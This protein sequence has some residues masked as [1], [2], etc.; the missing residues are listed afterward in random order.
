MV[1]AQEICRLKGLP[2][3]DDWCLLWGLVAEGEG[4]A[5]LALKSK[6]ITADQVAD[7]IKERDGEKPT[8]SPPFTG[9]VRRILEFG[10]RE[11]LQLGHNYVGTEHILLGFVRHW[12]GPAADWLSKDLSLSPSEIRSEVISILSGYKKNEDKDPMP[13][14]RVRQILFKGIAPGGKEGF[15]WQPLVVNN[16]PFLGQEAFQAMKEQTESLR[17]LLEADSFAPAEVTIVNPDGWSYTFKLEDD[18][19]NL[20]YYVVKVQS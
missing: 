3:I 19:D 14:E 17:K 8:W 18:S 4:V 12:E 6:R 20:D 11:A 13:A 5:T 1:L 7:Q 16:H 10:L 9:R 2:D 15:S